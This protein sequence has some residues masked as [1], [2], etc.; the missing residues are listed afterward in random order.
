MNEI[1][2]ENNTFIRYNKKQRKAVVLCP[3][4]KK[5]FN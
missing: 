2:L 5:P 3:L 4:R 1:A